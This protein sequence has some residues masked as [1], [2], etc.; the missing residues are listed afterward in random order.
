MN[1]PA[2]ALRGEAMIEIGGREHVLRPSFEN[3]VAAEAELGSLFELVERASAG[4]LT[5][6]EIAAL[7]WHCLPANDRPVREQVGTAVMALGLVRAIGPVRIILA[8]ALQ[9]KA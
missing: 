5:L 7:L 6:A 4:S 8:Q 1:R 2:N 3:L 9:G